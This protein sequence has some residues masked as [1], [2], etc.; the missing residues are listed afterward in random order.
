MCTPPW[1]RRGEGQEPVAATAAI[2]GKT[3]FARVVGFYSILFFTFIKEKEN[4]FTQGSR[5]CF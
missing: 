4:I 1:S 2:T 3:T 5:T